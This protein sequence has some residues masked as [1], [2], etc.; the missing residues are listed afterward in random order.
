MGGFGQIGSED[1]STEIAVVFDY[2]WLMKNIAIIIFSFLLITGCQKRSASLNEWSGKLEGIQ[3]KQG[4]SPYCFRSG[5]G[6]LGW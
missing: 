1:Q 6:G 2:F 5:I 4:L 3:G